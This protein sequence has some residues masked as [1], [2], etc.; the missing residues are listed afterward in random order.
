MATPLGVA[1][2]PA[3]RETIVHARG[4]GARQLFLAGTLMCIVWLA[5]LTMLVRQAQLAGF[6]TDSAALASGPALA[7]LAPFHP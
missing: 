7:F 3:R 5:A 6:A 1:G 2:W 4:A